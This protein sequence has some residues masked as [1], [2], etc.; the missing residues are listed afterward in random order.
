VTNA[1]GT[2]STDTVYADDWHI[3]EYHMQ[4]WDGAYGEDAEF[5]KIRLDHSNRVVSLW[6]RAELK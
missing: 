6:L 5:L 3:L 4:I 2:P 1:L